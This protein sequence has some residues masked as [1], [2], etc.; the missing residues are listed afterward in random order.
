MNP[1]NFKR[2]RDQR[3]KVKNAETKVTDGRTME[4]SV[5]ALLCKR[6]FEMESD[7]GVKDRCMYA[8]D[9]ATVGRMS[10]VGGSEWHGV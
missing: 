3:Q 2:C 10:E 6:L 5:V 7:S 8:F 9:Y 4:E 1:T